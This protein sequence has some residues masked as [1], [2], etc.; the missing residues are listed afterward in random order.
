MLS[1]LLI[2]FTSCLVSFIG[3]LQLGP[4]NLFV[5]N[6]VLFSSKKAAFWVALGGSLP[7]FIYCGLAI[8]AS[9]FLKT[10]ELFLFGF[11]IMFILILIYIAVIFFFKKPKEAHFTD[12]S[13][14]HIA[15]N[16][17]TYFI[18]GFS[19]AALN[20]QLLPFWVF[21]QIYFNSVKLLQIKSN[22]H[23]FSFILGAGLGA[24]LLLMSLVLLVTKYKHKVKKYVNNKYYNKILAILFLLIAIQQ[25]ISLIN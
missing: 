9:F 24:F 22:L 2:L 13:Q 21:V 8:Y 23:H 1:A 10:S 4:V 11:K 6:S 7:E 20:P 15:K 19:L 25:L 17:M 16:P 3:S 18:K 12:N 5:I 14:K